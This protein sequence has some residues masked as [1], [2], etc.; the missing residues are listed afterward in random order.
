MV[1]P[2]LTCLQAKPWIFNGIKCHFTRFNKN[3]Y[4]WA[5]RICLYIKCSTKVFNDHVTCFNKKRFFRFMLHVKVGLTIHFYTPDFFACVI[6]VRNRASF[7]K[8]CRAAIRQCILNGSV[9][10]S[11]GKYIDRFFSDPIK[12][13]SN[14]HY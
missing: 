8:E 7:S 5:I 14:R 10:R 13:I 4:S 1:H 9:N 11:N 3:F 12:H 2:C 6:R